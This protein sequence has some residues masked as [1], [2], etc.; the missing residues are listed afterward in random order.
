MGRGRCWNGMGKGLRTEIKITPSITNYYIY[1]TNDDNENRKILSICLISP[2]SDSHMV[3][4]VEKVA[5]VAT[6]N[7]CF[8]PRFPRLRLTWAARMQFYFAHLAQRRQV[9]VRIFRYSL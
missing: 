9:S 6:A 4:N 7:L 8:I 3:E 5:S 1:D 2:V